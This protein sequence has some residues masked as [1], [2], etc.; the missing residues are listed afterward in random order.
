MPPPLLFSH[1]DVCRSVLRFFSDELVVRRTHFSSGSE[2]PVN[3]N[4]TKY[5]AVGFN[6][7]KCID[8]DYFNTAITWK[9][10]N[11]NIFRVAALFQ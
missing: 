2:Q 10:I 7:I 11:K 8:P 4:S 6:F 5:A 9:L 1:M 3:T